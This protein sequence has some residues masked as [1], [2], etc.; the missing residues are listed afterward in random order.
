MDEL[1]LC[2]ICKGRIFLSKGTRHRWYVCHLDDLK[3]SCS[4]EQRTIIA[5]YR[6]EAISIWNKGEK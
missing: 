4:N 6:V 3:L 1:K 5:D 2:P